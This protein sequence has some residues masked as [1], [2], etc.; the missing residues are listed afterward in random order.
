MVM[1]VLRREGYG[2]YVVV[3]VLYRVYGSNWWLD[4]FIGVVVVIGSG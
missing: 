2:G 4:G 3:E 1:G